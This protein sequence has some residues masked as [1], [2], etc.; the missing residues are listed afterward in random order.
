MLGCRDNKDENVTMPTAHTKKELWETTPPGC[1][2]LMTWDFNM[3]PKSTLT[4]SKSMFN[5]QDSTPNPTIGGIISWYKSSPALQTTYFKHKI[6]TKFI[7][8]YRGV[9]ISTDNNSLLT[10][11]P[12]KT[13]K[14]TGPPYLV[15][16]AIDLYK[17]VETKSASSSK[18]F[19]SVL[20][21]LPT[22][23][24]SP[25]LLFLFKSQDTLEQT[26]KSYFSTPPLYGGFKM[27]FPPGW[28][29]FTG[30][31]FFSST[32]SAELFIS[33]QQKQI[34]K[35]LTNPLLK[36][37]PWIELLKSVSVH[38]EGTKV[39]IQWSNK[40]KN[41]ESLL[42]RFKSLTIKLMNR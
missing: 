17:R 29:L 31:L 27:L 10:A 5:F 21:S 35:L 33:Q 39:Y 30:V 3:F 1:S 12:A 14:I 2:A 42:S 36:N 34:V 38:P 23:P 26:L 18:E 4:L 19:T 25:A 8:N 22:G 11:T 20:K 28:I 9:P 6:K 15:K 16:M 32:T 41:G 7:N 24:L 40:R 13:M 37:Y